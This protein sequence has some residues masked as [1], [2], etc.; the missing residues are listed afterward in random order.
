VP[1]WRECLGG[2]GFHPKW[3]TQSD[4]DGPSKDSKE[5][6]RGGAGG[7][8]HFK[9]EVVVGGEHENGPGRAFG[10]Q[11]RKPSRLG[12]VS[13]W[14]VQIVISLVYEVCENQLHGG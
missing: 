11:N 4:M 3:Q 7:G 5:K 8:M 9:F 1:R 13:V 6:C 12:S 10:T 2:G 14:G